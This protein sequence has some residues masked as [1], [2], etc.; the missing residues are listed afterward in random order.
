MHSGPPDAIC[1]PDSQAAK[2]RKVV[3]YAAPLLLKG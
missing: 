3:D 2:K 1:I